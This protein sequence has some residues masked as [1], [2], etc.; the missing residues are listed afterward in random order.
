MKKVRYVFYK[1][2]FDLWNVIRGKRKMH[3]IDDGIN[4]HTCIV[5]LPGVIWQEKR[6]NVFKWAKAVWDFIRQCY[7]HV[8]VWVQGKYFP[9]HCHCPD[10]AVMVFE[11]PDLPGEYNGTCYT[12]TMRGEYNGTVKRPA[13]EVFTHP[14]RWDW[15]EYEVTDDSFED[16]KAW[17]DYRTRPDVNKGYGVKTIFRF[18]L[19]LWFVK[20]TKLDDPKREICSEHAEGWG[21]RLWRCIRWMKTIPLTIPLLNEI[22]I[23]S[24]RKLFRDLVHRHHVPTYS[25]ATGR[26]VYDENGRKVN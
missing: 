5:N 9:S 20:K 3:L 10:E 1:A 2:K 23:R 17:A 25:L 11:T 14:E 13:Q 12:S 7:S 22:R 24:P 15:Q 6:W 21:V 16:A 18:A 8:E 26:V 19:P 4:I